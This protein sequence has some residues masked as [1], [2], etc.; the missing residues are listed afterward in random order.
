MDDDNL[1]YTSKSALVAHYRD[2]GAIL[3]T[4][5]GDPRWDGLCKR[6]LLDCAR[7][8]SRWADEI[9]QSSEYDL[10]AEMIRD[11]RLTKLLAIV[12]QLSEIRTK[13]HD[14]MLLSEKKLAA[15]RAATKIANDAGLTRMTL[16]TVFNE[17]QT[18]QTWTISYFA[19]SRYR[20]GIFEITVD[21]ETATILNA[22]I[23]Y[24]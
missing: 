4:D 5:A 18:P 21:H 11:Q 19:Q 17:Q 7:Q 8:Y 20:G 2:C 12:K 22:A 14:Q 24:S 13:W 6:L 23:E 15:V 16:T 3:T 10:T 1:S 9:E